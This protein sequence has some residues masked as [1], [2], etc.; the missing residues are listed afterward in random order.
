LADFIIEEVCQFIKEL[1]EKG[2][3]QY[4]SINLSGKQ[5]VEPNFADKLL[6]TFDK[7]NLPSKNLV[8]EVTESAVVERLEEACAV[9]EKIREYGVKVYL[10]DFGT[11]YS[12]LNYLSKLPID[13]IKIDK[14]FVDFV[15]QNEKSEV[16]VRS[17]VYMAKNFKMNVVAEGVEYKEQKD[18]LEELGCDWHQG[19]LYF[20]PLDKEDAMNT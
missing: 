2:S 15:H 8:V 12:S 5:L 13:C 9:L 1:S 6:H 11:G 7:Y 3:D 19:Y 18:K 20:K 14:S 16:M 10:D 4:V 17:I